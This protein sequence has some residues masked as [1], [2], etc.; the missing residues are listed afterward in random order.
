[1]YLSCLPLDP[2][3]LFDP[4]DLW[5][6]LFSSIASSVSVVRVNMFDEVKWL[7]CRNIN[8]C[9]LPQ[10]LYR[11]SVDLSFSSEDMVLSSSLDRTLIDTLC[12]CAILCHRHN[13]HYMAIISDDNDL[14][15]FSHRDS[16]ATLI[17]S[18]NHVSFLSST[19]L[20]L[21]VHYL[22]IL[23]KEEASCDWVMD[24]S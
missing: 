15:I 10:S 13:R 12:V 9:S 5:I 22:T 17:S 20:D 18:A 4:D 6:L 21:G 7:K 8:S 16:F 11:T 1:M 24:T 23:W 19:L 3:F 14:W 2:W